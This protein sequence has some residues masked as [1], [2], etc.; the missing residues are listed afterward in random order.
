VTLVFEGAGACDLLLT[1]PDA[2]S[3][4]S[5]VRA[6]RLGPA[7]FQAAL[8]EPGRW[9]VVAVCGRRERAV[10]PATIDVRPGGQDLTIRMSWPQ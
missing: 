3:G 7:M 4:M 10:T 9:H 8:P 2:R 5:V 6:T 1:G